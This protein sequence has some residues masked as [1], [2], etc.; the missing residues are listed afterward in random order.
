MCRKKNIQQKHLRVFSIDVKEG[1]VIEVL[2]NQKVTEKIRAEMKL[3][4]NELFRKN[5]RI[6]D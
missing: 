2:I 1:G 3:T 6:E 5:K 4:M